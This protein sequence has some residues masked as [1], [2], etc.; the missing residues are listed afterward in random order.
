M[1]TLTLISLFVNLDRP[2]T[3]QAR[4]RRCFEAICQVESGGNPRAINRK[5]DA[6]GIAQIR[7]CM[8]AEANRVLGRRKY[9]LGDR[10][11]VERSWEIFRLYSRYYAPNGPEETWARNWQGGPHGHKKPCTLAYWQKVKEILE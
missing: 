2:A 6:V 5:E 3:I 1:L 10:L 11:S 9:G 4:L 8:V 7:P